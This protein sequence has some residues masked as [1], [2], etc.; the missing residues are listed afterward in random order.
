M[1]KYLIKNIHIVNEG[2]I[3]NADVLITN[4]RI[5]TILPQIVNAGGNCIE[6]NGEGKYLFPGCID[7]Q[8][9]FREPGL[10]HK[11]TIYTESK[12][13][14]A[15]GVTS[16]M[17]MPNT[18]PNA[19]TQELLEEKYKIGAQ[20]SLANYSFFMGTGNDNADEVLKTNDRKKDICGVKIFMGAST[21]NMLVDNPNT[22]DKIFRESEV[23]I[24]THCE[25][26]KIIRQNLE[27]AKASGRELTAADH[28]IIRDEEVCYESSLYAIQIAKKYNTR[29]HILHITTE[30]ELQLFTNM[31]PLK[32]KRITAE[33]CVHHLHFTS[34]DYA[35]LGNQI[36]CNPAIKAPHNKEALWNA[37]LDD[38]LDVIATDHAPHT[39]EEKNEPYLK[40]HAGLPLVQHPLLLMLHYYKEGRI[41]LEKIAEKMSHA[42]ADCF[43]IK[44]RGYIREGY[45]ADLVMVDLNTTYKVTK[46]NILYKCGWSPLEG[47]EFPATITH[48]FI[49]GHLAYGIK[50]FNESQKGQRL[51]FDR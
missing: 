27:K 40:A 24:A 11:A 9:H 10:T 22:L 33:V 34:D 30:R 45:H 2:S 50:G 38:R 7:D 21:G 41:S 16:F 6:I 14:V 18:V 39:W 51:V 1:Q 35:R 28:P 8:V 47:F 32:D 31:F 48:T 26:E 44:E 3:I 25:D 36:K 42:V 20:T 29:L 13:A 46:E 17:E 15:G 5:D 37:L 12:A 4:G 43:Q 23:L 19:L 49:N